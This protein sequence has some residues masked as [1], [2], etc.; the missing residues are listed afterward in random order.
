MLFKEEFERI[1]DMAIISL[2]EY[3][4]LDFAEKEAYNRLRTN[5]LF[6]SHDTRVVGITSSIPGEGKSS[7]TMN[8]SASMA[9]FGKRVIFI[10]GDLRKSVLLGRYR[11][12]KPIKGLSH[13]LSGQSSEEE[14]LFKSD[15]DNL[16]LIFAGPM[17]PNPSEVLGSKKFTILIHSLKERYDY[18]FIDTPPIVSVIDPIVIS[19]VCDGMILVI[20]E[21]TI[22][23]KIARNAVKEMEKAGS[24]F[25]GTVLNKV[26]FQKNSIYGEYYGKYYGHQDQIG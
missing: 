12:S 6:T 18:I 14:I 19:N 13:Y 5:L 7:V 26:D 23:Y 16:D 9:K 21:G 1:G 3:F 17:P 2:K 15:I 22:S 20:E 11:L 10:D 25:L 4:E 8:L 24:K